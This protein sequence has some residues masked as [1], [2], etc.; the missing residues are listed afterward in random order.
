MMVLAT[1]VFF[2]HLLYLSLSSNILTWIVSRLLVSIG[3]RALPLV[4]CGLGC[5]G[6]ITF[7]MLF[8]LRILLFPTEAT[9][10]LG[11]WMLPAGPVEENPS[12]DLTLRLG[13][14]EP[15]QIQ[16]PYW[17]GPS[18]DP[19]SLLPDES[20][21]RVFD[22]SNAR[23]LLVSSKKKDREMPIDQIK[24]LPRRPECPSSIPIPS[25]WTKQVWKPYL[26]ITY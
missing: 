6:G 20:K 24:T 10:S 19:F 13:L 3:G 14:P 2:F 26:H 11:N 18:E 25:G 5:S 22:E 7:A 21:K 9:T 8:I 1:I 12:M 4:L 15:E 23:L 16:A 17:T